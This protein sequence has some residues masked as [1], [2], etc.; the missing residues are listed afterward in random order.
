MEWRKE[1][2]PK[3]LIK[4]SEGKMAESKGALLAKSV[5]KHAGRAKEKVRISW[6]FYKFTNN[7]T[8]RTNF[9]FDAVKTVLWMVHMHIFMLP[10]S[11]KTT[12]HL[13][14]LTSIF[15]FY[16]FDPLKTR[17]NCMYHQI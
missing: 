11:G 5:Q 6:H 15:T 3:Q 16:Y 2:K 10:A 12:T 8:A 1:W 9:M 4:W 13:K 7:S 14:T 17:D